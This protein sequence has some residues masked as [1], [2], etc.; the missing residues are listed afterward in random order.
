M[1]EKITSTSEL[2]ALQGKYQA[3]IKAEPVRILVCAGTGCL[4][5]DLREEA[6]KS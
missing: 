3:A 6:A 1:T 2:N 5:A 4:I